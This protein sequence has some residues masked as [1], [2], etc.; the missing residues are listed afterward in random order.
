MMTHLLTL[1]TPISQIPTTFTNFQQ[2][3]YTCL[4]KQSQ[5]ITRQ[6][7]TAGQL[8]QD[9]KRIIDATG[10]IIS[11]D[12]RNSAQVV[13][14]IGQALNGQTVEIVRQVENRFSTILDE[15]LGGIVSRLKEHVD[16]E[17]TLIEALQ[18]KA[19]HDDTQH[20]PA[21]THINTDEPLIRAVS[22]NDP[23]ETQIGPSTTTTLKRQL[24]V[25]SITASEPD[26]DQDPVHNE[27]EDS[28]GRLLHK[29]D[30]TENSSAEFKIPSQIETYK[31]G[32]L[33]AVG[34][35]AKETPT[36]SA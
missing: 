21:P 3:V 20:P 24:S 28:A 26:C 8:Q 33:D 4:D 11:A 6:D 1:L 35:K 27:S 15:K 34:G 30:V 10:Q 31:S 19:V 29:P 23:A 17:R 32:S 16:L 25:S 14:A 9:A 18:A 5:S 12:D 7:K 22:Q 13:R 36:V 2:S